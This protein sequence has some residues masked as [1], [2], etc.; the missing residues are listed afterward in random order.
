MDVTRTNHAAPAVG[1]KREAEA[2]S[3]VA[4]AE[5]A[6]VSKIFGSTVA[7]SDVSFQ[8]FTGEVLALVGE[9]GAGK[10]TCVKMLG[11]VYHPDGGTVRIAGEDVNFSTALEA[12]KHGVAV[13]HQ[14]PG[15]FADLSIAENVF[16]GQPLRS[17]SGV[18]TS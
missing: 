9:N 18:S 14:H 15:L 7:V 4:A 3:P 12:H 10:S 1:G 2:Y 8:L 11:G 17:R 13:V 5:L 6:G 16:A